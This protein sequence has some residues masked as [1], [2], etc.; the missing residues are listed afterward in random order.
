MNHELKADMSAVGDCCVEHL[1]SAH[2]ADFILTNLKNQSETNAKL[3]RTSLIRTFKFWSL[4]HRDKLRGFLL[5]W[6]WQ[7][8]FSFISCI[9]YP[10]LHNPAVYA[11][12]NN[13]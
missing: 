3:Q 13:I 10:F 12:S 1:C 9:S 8:D 11:I 5:F 7:S 6:S 4:L 2:L